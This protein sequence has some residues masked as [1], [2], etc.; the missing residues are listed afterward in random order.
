MKQ[1]IKK[2]WIYILILFGFFISSCQAGNFTATVAATLPAQPAVTQA[3]PEAIPEMSAKPQPQEI[4]FQGCPPQG[5]GGDPKLNRLKNRVDQGDYVPV[6]FD[7]VMGLTWPKATERS[8][9][10]SWSSADAAAIGRNEGIPIS[11]EGYLAMARESG[12]ESCN[13]HGADPAFHD[14]HIWL[15]KEP[16]DARAAAII[17]ETTPRVRPD[18]PGWTLTAL[19]KIVK[20]QEKVRIS[21]WL[22]FDPEHPDQLGKTRGTL[23]EIH[24][25]M[26][27][28]IVS[29]DGQITELK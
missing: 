24:P 12:P 23:W 28:E 26:K 11:V 6:S 17:V 1:A 25:V 18:H 9:M 19:D 22:F 10:S 27:I 4:D 7:A 21:G 5:D 2:R 29:P 16:G 8:E 15:T 13:C 14:W 20:N 3:S